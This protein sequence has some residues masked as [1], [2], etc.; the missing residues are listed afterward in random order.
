ML[1]FCCLLAY[2]C[3]VIFREAERHTS[4]SWV[5][6]EDRSG[7]LGEGEAGF[8]TSSSAA[9]SELDIASLGLSVSPA[10]ENTTITLGRGSDRLSWINRLTRVVAA[11]IGLKEERGWRSLLP[12]PS[13]PLEP[14]EPFCCMHAEGPALG[15]RG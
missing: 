15:A 3:V 8:R 10:A 13:E 1:C 9:G 12:H 5:L 14:L 11:G 4:C 2:V 7:L 6:R